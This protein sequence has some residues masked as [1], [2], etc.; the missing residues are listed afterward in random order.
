MNVCVKGTKDYSI[1]YIMSVM[2]SWY[3]ID[4]IAADENFISCDK[5]ARLSKIIQFRLYLFSV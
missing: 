1:L 3:Q 5:V 4:F 2:F